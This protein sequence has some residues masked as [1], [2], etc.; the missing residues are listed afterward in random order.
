MVLK[1][2][3]K[4]ISPEYSFLACLESE[5]G[6]FKSNFYF[7]SEISGSGYLLKYYLESTSGYRVV[8]QVEKEVELESKEIFNTR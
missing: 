5:I 8:V 1:I 4:L 6:N 2:F 7:W 3:C